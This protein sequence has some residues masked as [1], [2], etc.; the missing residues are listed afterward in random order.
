VGL[1]VF[2]S[3]GLLDHAVPHAPNNGGQP[4][5]QGWEKGKRTIL[6]PFVHEMKELASGMK[7]PENPAAQLLK[8]MFRAMV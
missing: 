5:K 7:F 2:T 8:P 6:D 1:T 3:P 4:W